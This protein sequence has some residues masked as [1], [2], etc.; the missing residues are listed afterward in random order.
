MEVFIW[1]CVL[2]VRTDGVKALKGVCAETQCRTHRPGILGHRMH[3]R[4]HASKVFRGQRGFIVAHLEMRGDV[5]L[6]LHRPILISD[7]C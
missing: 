5:L 3:T 2:S 4:T 1:G 6:F 7:A